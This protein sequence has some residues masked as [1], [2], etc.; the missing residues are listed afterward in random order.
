MGIIL[1]D[2]RLYKFKDFKTSLGIKVLELL[3]VPL[4]PFQH[5]HDSLSHCFCHRKYYL[6]IIKKLFYLHARQRD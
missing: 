4:D 5:S 6:I 3:N 1:T 2:P